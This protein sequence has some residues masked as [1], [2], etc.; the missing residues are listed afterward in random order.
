MTHILG[1]RQLTDSE[2]RLNTIPLLRHF[3]DM[4]YWWC[5]LLHDAEI[6][7]IITVTTPD[8]EMPT[9]TTVNAGEAELEKDE[10]PA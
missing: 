6:E 10:G 7:M 1:Q 3:Y 8:T 5:A 2:K 4:P 9:F